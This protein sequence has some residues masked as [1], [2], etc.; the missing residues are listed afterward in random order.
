MLSA[1][2]KSYY[3][4]QGCC[5]VCDHKVDNT[6]GLRTVGCQG[7]KYP[8]RLCSKNICRDCLHLFEYD[9][10]KTAKWVNGEVF[11][12]LEAYCTFYGKLNY[13]LSK[14]KLAKNNRSKTTSG[15]KG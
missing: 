3:G 1:K 6:G 10:E 2:K 12:D 11:F 9:D 13:E 7:I 15:E 4:F 8:V 14:D 5:Q